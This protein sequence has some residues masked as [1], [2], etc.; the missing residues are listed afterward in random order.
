VKQG[1]QTRLARR[2]MVSA[3]ARMAQ[4]IRSRYVAIGGRAHSVSRVLRR[5]SISQWQQFVDSRLVLFSPRLSFRSSLNHVAMAPL[6]EYRSPSLDQVTRLLRRLSERESRPSSM[7]ERRRE[8]K[9]PVVATMRT[10]ER[11]AAARAVALPVD[12]VL[13]RTR[14]ANP[15]TSPRPPARNWNEPAVPSDAFTPVRMPNLFPFPAPEMNR[16]TNEVLKAIDRRV[17]AHRERTGRR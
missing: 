8:E 6:S 10:R 16:L 7:I 3:A 5:Q 17:I 12:R 2:D 11:R 9:P 14:S 4:A 1:T 13:A 15:A